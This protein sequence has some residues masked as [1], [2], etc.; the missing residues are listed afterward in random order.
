MPFKPMK[1]RDYLQW[2]QQYGWS[3]EK[4]HKDWKLLNEDGQVIKPNII[5][6]HPGNEVIAPHVNATKK[7]L[8]SEGLEP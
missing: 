1:L 4:G 5:V 2:I 6:T 8:T 3:L 7:L